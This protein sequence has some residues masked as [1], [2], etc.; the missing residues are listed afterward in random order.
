MEGDETSENRGIEEH[1]LSG[2]EENTDVDYDEDDNTV[3]VELEKALDLRDLVQLRPVT[4]ELPEKPHHPPEEEAYFDQSEM[5]KY[6]NPECVGINSDESDDDDDS[7][8]SPFEKLAQKMEKVTEDGGVLKLTVKHGQGCMVPDGG[9]VT[10]HYNAYLEYAD[11]TFDSSR[12]RNRPLKT[13]IG[14]KSVI[15]G[16][17]LALQTMKKNE[18]AKFLIQ[19]FYAYG[20]M[21][22][23]PRIPKN[24]IVLYEVEVI[25]FIDYGPAAEFQNM[26]LEERKKIM[27]EKAYSIGKAEHQA[28]NYFF[29]KQLFGKA[30]KKYL[31]GIDILL[32]TNLKDE[33]EQDKM[34]KLIVKLYLNGALCRL[35]MDQPDRAITMANE[36]LK[37]KSNN[38]KALYCKGKAKSIFHEYKAAR[39][40][41]Q[42]ANRLKPHD[43]DI[44]KELR[45]LEEKQQRELAREKLI[46]SR[47]L[48]GQSNTGNNESSNLV[49]PQHSSEVDEKFKAVVKERL[50]EFCK[51][52]NLLEM[53]FP[54]FLSGPEIH[55]LATAA[56]DMG[57]VFKMLETAKGTIKVCKKQADK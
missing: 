44:I 33:Q 14:A 52:K 6:L 18:I 48:Q 42:L 49:L 32:N 20:A 40:C 25:D 19:P 23:P 21:G 16:L 26:S 34:E 17:E 2:D 55:C 30:I 37:R 9:F 12:L 57:L 7:N 39:H 50:E 45:D 53:P 43:P 47:M 1:E 22:C 3:E 54:T 10:F 8:K 35:R 29:K 11:E 56:E 5:L 4:L 15:P 36:V 31:A 27:F 28:G 41:L 13:R 51:D 38:V 24:A 46:C